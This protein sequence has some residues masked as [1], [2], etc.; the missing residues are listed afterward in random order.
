MTASAAAACPATTTLT[1]AA[2]ENLL[3]LWNAGW[4]VPRLARHFRV[5]D[6]EVMSLIRP[7]VA[8]RE[9]DHVAYDDAL[10][11]ARPALAASGRVEAGE[12]VPA[13]ADHEIHVRDVMARGGFPAFDFSGARPRVVWANPGARR[14]RDAGALR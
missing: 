4:A 13:F 3:A 7:E 1:K 14:G 10:T 8:R 2:R 5:T 9:R 11:S 6:G 12:G